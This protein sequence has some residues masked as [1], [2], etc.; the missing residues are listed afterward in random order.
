MCE[1]GPGAL[2]AEFEFGL[3]EVGDEFGLYWVQ[4]ESVGHGSRDN[5]F[6]QVFDASESWSDG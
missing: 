1:K 3:H 4:C 2:D 5:V 6:G